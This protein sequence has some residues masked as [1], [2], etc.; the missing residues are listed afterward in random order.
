MMADK[1]AAHMKVHSGMSVQKRGF[2]QHRPRD[3]CM[4]DISTRALGTSWTVPALLLLFPSTSGHFDSKIVASRGGGRPSS[5][6]RG[7]HWRGEARKPGPTCSLGC[8]SL[9]CPV[10]MQQA[11]SSFQRPRDLKGAQ[12][13]AVAE[14]ES[15]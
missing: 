13:T 2:V 1:G 11:C 12:G 15:R 5:N 14:Q 10:A 4:P 3:Q 7:I 8:Q 9:P 6:A